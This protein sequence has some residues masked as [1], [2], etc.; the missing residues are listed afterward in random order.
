MRWFASDFVC[1]KHAPALKASLVSD[2]VVARAVNHPWF[3]GVQ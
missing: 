3:Q 1:Q 2:A